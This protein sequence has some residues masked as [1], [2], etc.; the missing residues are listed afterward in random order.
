MQQLARI[1]QA[2]GI[3]HQ[4]GGAGL[5]IQVILTVAHRQVVRQRLLLIALPF[6]HAAEIIIGLQH[7]PPQRQHGLEMIPGGVQLV[8]LQ[9]Q[10]A[11]GIAH[12]DIVRILLGEGVEHLQRRIQPLELGEQARIGDA[13]VGIVG[14]L[15]LEFP[16]QVV[17]RLLLVSLQAHHPRPQHHRLTPAG[18]QRLG[19]VHRGQGHVELALAHG[20][21]GVGQPGI[22]VILATGEEVFHH[23]HRGITVLLARQLIGDLLKA[24]IG[25]ALGQTKIDIELGLGLRHPP[26]IQEQRPQHAVRIGIFRRQFGP[27]AGRLQRRLQRLGIQRHARRAFGETGVAGAL[28]G[29]PV[30][31]DGNAQLAALR[32][33][34]RH[35]QL[36][37]DLRRNLSLRLDGVHRGRGGRGCGI[38][39][40]R[41]RRRGLQRADGT[42]RHRHDSQ[43]DGNQLL[44]L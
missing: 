28:R 2:P 19:L 35:Q 41:L 42:T 26:L 7:A 32:G 8:Q 29:R 14:Q 20:Q 27:Q 5:G 33:D 24:V 1:L 16:G 17:H 38:R 13:H 34:V 23:R 36:E 37:K 4:A 18:L 43:Q 22:G 12:L 31:G 3:G 44:H 11:G 21:P 15:A 10:H 9:R 39:N 30:I 40:R 6:I 25:L